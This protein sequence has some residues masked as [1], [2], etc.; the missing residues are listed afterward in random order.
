MIVLVIMNYRHESREY[1]LAS[2]IQLSLAKQLL[3]PALEDLSLACKLIVT[4]IAR[5]WFALSEH[6]DL[7][8][9]VQPYVARE[10]RRIAREYYYKRVDR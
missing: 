6:S 9:R 7:S 3:E 4:S 10:Y 5:E 8:D 1:W 2:S